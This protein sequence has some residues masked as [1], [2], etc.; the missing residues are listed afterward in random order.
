LKGWVFC[1]NQ[2]VLFIYTK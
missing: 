1:W 2:R